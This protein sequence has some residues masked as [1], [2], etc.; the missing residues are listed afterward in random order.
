[1][2]TA[3]AP[4]RPAAGRSC[5][6]A[7]AAVGRRRRT[8]FLRPQ[9]TPTVPATPSPTASATDA[10][11]LTQCESS[12]TPSG[13]LSTSETGFR[14]HRAGLLHVRG[15]GLSPGLAQSA[16]VWVP[17]ETPGHWWRRRRRPGDRP[18]TPRRRPRARSRDGVSSSNIVIDSDRITVTPSGALGTSP[19][20]L[21]AWLCSNSWDCPGQPSASNLPVQ[22]RRP[23]VHH[24]SDGGTSAAPFTVRPGRHSSTPC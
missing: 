12:A 24:G 19:T 14:W 10:S 20:T 9:A 16:L 3:K 5:F 22:R 21:P 18:G 8:W 1:M 7:A 6:P 2:N 15:A 13:T 17:A 11:P 23:M 4:P